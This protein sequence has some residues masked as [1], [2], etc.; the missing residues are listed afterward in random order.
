LTSTVGILGVVC[1]SLPEKL[2]FLSPEASVIGS[3][4]LS[5]AASFSVDGSPDAKDGAGAAAA[6]AASSSQA[7]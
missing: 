1:P 3:S 7:C 6:A 5:D 2:Q 4:L